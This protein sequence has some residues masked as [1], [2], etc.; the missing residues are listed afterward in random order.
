MTSTM[1]A[2][3]L[4]SCIIA[5]TAGRP[6]ADEP[7]VFHVLAETRTC[8]CEIGD[9]SGIYYNAAP[10]QQVSFNPISPWC[11]VGAEDNC[12]TIGFAELFYQDGEDCTPC[13]YRI[14][15][16]F[17]FSEPC[18]HIPSCQFV[19]CE[20]NDWQNASGQSSLSG[21]TTFL[22][23]FTVQCSNTAQIAMQIVCQDG[24]LG[25]MGPT[26]EWGWKVSCTECQ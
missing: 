16:S 14:E 19:C 3:S 1:I 8:Y 21:D 6:T 9:T 10:C 11:W 23:E 15:V 17:E 22:E 20:A 24:A 12:A 25:Y 13:R 7:R 2:L 5:T 18:P 26:Y 4:A